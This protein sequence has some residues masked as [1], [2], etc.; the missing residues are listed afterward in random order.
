MQKGVYTAGCEKCG[1]PNY[2][3]I[4]GKGGFDPVVCRACKSQFLGVQKGSRNNE[5]IA[6]V[7]I[8]AKVVPAENVVKSPVQSDLG[9]SRGAVGVGT[10]DKKALPVSGEV[11]EA[12]KKNDR[13]TLKW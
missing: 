2:M 8:P 13:K 1:Q 6:Q 3:H 5:Y 4:D 12:T 9:E 11:S 7:H 10:K